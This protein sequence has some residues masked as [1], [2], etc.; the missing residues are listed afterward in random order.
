MTKPE[1]GRQEGA[2]ES[3]TTSQRDWLENL[4]N[5]LESSAGGHPAPPSP[6][7]IGRGVAFPTGASFRSA[8]SESGQGSLQTLTEPE[9]PSI[10]CSVSVEEATPPSPACRCTLRASLEQRA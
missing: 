8:L 5:R 10:R 3:A 1:P 2:N 4:T 9:A 7:G 6:P